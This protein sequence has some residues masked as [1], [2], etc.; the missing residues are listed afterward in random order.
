MLIFIAIDVVGYESTL[1]YER[2]EHWVAHTHQVIGS[3]SPMLSTIMSFEGGVRGFIF[4]GDTTFLDGYQQDLKDMDA[5]IIMARTLTADNP[6]QLARID[7]LADLFDQKARQDESAISVYHR[8]GLEAAKAVI[9]ELGG[10][11]ITQHVRQILRDMTD[12]ENTLLADRIR[13]SE[14]TLRTTLTLTAAG[15][16][17]GFLVLLFA[18]IQLRQFE[19]SRSAA[20]AALR[21][22]EALHRSIM[23]NFP[24]GSVIFFDKDLRYL[25]ADG[26]SLADAGHSRENLEGRTIWDIFPPEMVALLEPKYRLALTGTPTK[27]EVPFK[28]KIYLLQVH[29]AT[30]EDG[31]IFGGVVL[32]QNIT[33]QRK[34]EN[35]RAELITRLQLAFD[36]VKQ[37]TGML[38]ICAS[39]KK[40][41]DDTGYW[42]Q[43]EAYIGSHTDAEFTHG[44][45]PECLKKFY[46]QMPPPK[47]RT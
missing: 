43:V 1:G 13:T 30:D 2:T 34:S 8:D 31:N 42:H 15:S 16:I 25:R 7:T 46:E 38:P 36:D 21:E 33:A 11:K 5:E 35:D 29:P 45:C 47:A 39:C 14:D 20:S 23:R 3:L 26:S 27:F 37:L 4:T 22:S 41:R 18:F 17:A 10:V 9:S 19:R 6:R 24:D 28:E 32:S 44:M 12:E 40:I